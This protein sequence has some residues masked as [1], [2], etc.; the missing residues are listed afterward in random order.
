MDNDLEQIR[1]LKKRTTL[2]FYDETRNS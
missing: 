2:T 1:F